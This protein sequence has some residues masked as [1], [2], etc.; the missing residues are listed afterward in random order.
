VPRPRPGTNG[1]SRDTIHRRRAVLGV[2]LALAGVVAAG[3][4]LAADRYL[5]DD[6]GLQGPAPQT[7]KK[8]MWGPITFADGRS[9]FPTYRDLGVG[10]YGIQV[11]WDEIAP[12]KPAD[13]TNPKDPAYLWSSYLD[14]A[15]R[16]SRRN[17][18]KPMFQ[19]IGA[20]P[21]ANGGRD[22]HWAP[23]RSS[24]F[25]DFA[26][27]AARRYPGVNLWMIWGEP[28]RKPNW[29]PLTP[30]HDPEGP[31]TK[32][33][34]V[35]PHHYAQVLDDAYA[36]L[37]SVNRDNLVIGGNTYTSAGM[38]D[39]NPYQWIRYLR[40]PNGD[41]PRFDMWGHNPFGFA[42][43]EFEDE[44]SR[45]G[46]V[47]FADLERL[48]EELDENFPGPPKKLVLAEWGV[49]QGFKDKDLGYTRSPEEANEWI[50]A[51]FEIA[52]EWDR[53]YTLGWIHPVD[54]ERNSTGLLNINNKQK[55]SYDVYKG[56]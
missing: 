29:E 40:L 48:A 33:E 32:A 2:T 12:K 10:I 13:P 4:G 16:Q 11:H 22:W 30:A 26:T 43:P 36:A 31:L 46:V 3:V 9:L 37:K 53:V 25:A 27:A 47:A 1:V 21:W 39:I 44:P 18:I 23:R 50:E 51:G 6:D 34:Q 8:T 15:V 24:D 17:G 55:P 14:Y 28:N 35:A 56:S 7:E 19:L 38:D 52:R 54:T 20:P 45:E 5:D 41:P 42:E 49:P